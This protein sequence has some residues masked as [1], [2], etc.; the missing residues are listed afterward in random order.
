MTFQREGDEAPG[1][2]TGDVVLKLREKPHPFFKR[3]GNDLEHT[4]TISLSQALIGCTVPIRTLD[5]RVIPISVSDI[6]KP[7]STT[8]VKGEGMPKA[9]TPSE[10]GDLVLRFDVQF[11]TSLTL[12]QKEGLRKILP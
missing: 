3:N 8:R 5:G 1:A 7:D 9:R 12:A 2:P 6:V 11:P 4:A 10:R